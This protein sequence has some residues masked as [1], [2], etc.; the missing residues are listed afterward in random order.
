M[1]ILRK[2]IYKMESKTQRELRSKGL[3]KG[4]VNSP[5]VEAPV[6]KDVVPMMLRNPNTRGWATVYLPGP[7]GC[8]IPD[9][10]GWRGHTAALASRDLPG[11]PRSGGVLVAGKPGLCD[12]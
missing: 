4:K 9:L 10:K 2:V 3:Q 11:R 12:E 8:A 1:C 7:R 5:E 6:E